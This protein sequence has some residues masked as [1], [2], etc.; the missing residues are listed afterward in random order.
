[1]VRDI[2]LMN[3]VPNFIISMLNSEISMYIK[4]DE[5]QQFSRKFDKMKSKVYDDYTTE[6]NGKNNMKL[7]SSKIIDYMSY[8]GC[9]FEIESRITP[10]G[11]LMALKCRGKISE[12]GVD[13]IDVFIGTQENSADVSTGNLE[14]VQ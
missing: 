5:Q 7:F 8:L 1:L 12:D 14:L 13:D 9:D 4:G 10:D 2:A 11:S 6:V 3:K